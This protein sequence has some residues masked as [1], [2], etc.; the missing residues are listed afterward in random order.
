L[1]SP[2]T[3]P[4]ALSRRHGGFDRRHIGHID[5]SGMARPPH[6][7]EFHSPVAGVDVTA[8]TAAPSAGQ[9]AAIFL[10]DAARRTVR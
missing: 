1:T 8:I 3:R 5:L 10:A 6:S 9:P 2:S 4:K 7:D